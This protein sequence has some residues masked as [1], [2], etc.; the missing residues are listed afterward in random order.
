M[1]ASLALALAVIMSSSSDWTYSSAGRRDP[2]RPIVVPPELPSCARL[3]CLVPMRDFQLVGTVTD[4]ASPIAM[5]RDPQGVGYLV[6]K[7]SRV[8]KERYTVVAIRPTKVELVRVVRVG[9]RAIE[10][11][12][13]LEMPVAPIPPAVDLS[14]PEEDR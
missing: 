4:V 2:F 10:E 1:Y 6:R 3:T 12:F 13:E 11:R 9:Q 8:A 7:G 5:L 14:Q